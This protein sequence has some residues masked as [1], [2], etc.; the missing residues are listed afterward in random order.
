MK[1]FSTA[2]KRSFCYRIYGYALSLFLNLADILARW[3]LKVDFIIFRGEIAV[4]ESQVDLIIHLI[5]MIN[6]MVRL[7]F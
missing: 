6:I 1:M 2:I 7:K 4:S 3:S 5:G